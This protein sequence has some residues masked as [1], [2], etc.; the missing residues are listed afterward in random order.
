MRR[1]TPMKDPMNIKKLEVKGLPWPQ[2]EIIKNFHDPNTVIQKSRT[3]KM[4]LCFE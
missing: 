4:I 3:N 2:G 1:A